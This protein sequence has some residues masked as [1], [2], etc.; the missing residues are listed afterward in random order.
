MQL[1]PLFPNVRVETHQGTFPVQLEIPES[2]TLTDGEIKQI[3]EMA[4]WGVLPYTAGKVEGLR[5]IK[6]NREKPTEKQ[7]IALEGLL[8][9]GIGSNRSNLGR[10]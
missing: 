1:E 9:N 2:S 7:G 5:G 8:V 6:F 4:S 10:T 3:L